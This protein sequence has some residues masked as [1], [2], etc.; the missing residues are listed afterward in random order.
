MDFR[1][2]HLLDHFATRHDGFEDVLRAYVLA[3]E[4]LFL[5]LVL[6]LVVF[7]VARGEYITRA[8]GVTAGVSAAIALLIAKAVSDTVA[9]PRPFVSHHSIHDFLA[10]APDPGMPSD[11]ATAAF[12]IGTAIFLA[13]RRAGILVLVAATVLALGRV[14]L[15]VHYL[16]D[17]IV[18]AAL[19]AAVAVLVTNVARRLPLIRLA[20]PGRARPGQR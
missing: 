2:A 17:V 8:A 16:S 19:G 20:P 6:G 4:Y 18:G 9:R 5:A 15:G 14:F 12:A 11:H 7:A 1:I 10:H 13:N 3:S